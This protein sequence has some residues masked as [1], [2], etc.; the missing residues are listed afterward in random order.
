MMGRWYSGGRGIGFIWVQRESDTGAESHVDSEDLAG[1][2]RGLMCFAYLRS[3]NEAMCPEQREEWVAWEEVS[4]LSESL[5]S[6]S[7]LFWWISLWVKWEALTGQSKRRG[8]FC[9]VL[10][11]GSLASEW[12]IDYRGKGRSEQKPRDRLE[13]SYDSLHKRWCWL[14]PW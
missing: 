5:F 8:M 9:H 12:R 6:G 14:G 4:S 2:S 7:S 13:R 3:Q 1:A 11:T 10:T